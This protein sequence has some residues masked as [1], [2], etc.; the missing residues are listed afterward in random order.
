[1]LHKQT[2]SPELFQVLKSLMTLPILSPF[3]LVGGTALSLLKGHRISVD[4]DLFTDQ[5]YGTTDFVAIEQAL[6]EHFAV[7]DNYADAFPALKALENNLGLY[8]Y[9]GSREEDLIKTDILYWDAPF[10]FDALQIEGI[11]LASVEEIG[12]MKLDVI[13]RGGRKKDFW[14]LVE[15][16]SDYSL[17]HLLRVYE[18]KYPYN[19][20]ADVKRGL[21]DFTAAEEVPDP[22]CLRERTWEGVKEVIIREAA[23]L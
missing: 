23:Q 14:D 12:A 13:S 11:R 7:V 15:I 21:T 19:D 10:L 8:L 5:T 4:I 18:E 1:M 2:T 3:R 20:L 9:V 22:I 16:L 17:L 6:R